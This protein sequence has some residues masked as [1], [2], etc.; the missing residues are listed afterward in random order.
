MYVSTAFT[1]QIHKTI[2]VICMETLCGRGN[3]EVCS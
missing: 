2:T 1:E 3:P